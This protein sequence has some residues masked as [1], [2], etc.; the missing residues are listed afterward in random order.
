MLKIE[1]VYKKL[2]SNCP[3]NASQDS[4]KSCKNSKSTREFKSLLSFELICEIRLLR[5]LQREG[6]SNPA[7][8][9]FCCCKRRVVFCL[10]SFLKSVHRK[11][12]FL[13]AGELSVPVFKAV[14]QLPQFPLPSKIST[15]A[16]GYH[17]TLVSS[18]L[19]IV[20]RPGI[21][22]W[23][24]LDLFLDYFLEEYHGSS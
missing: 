24:F 12:M 2:P 17:R 6:K 19:L 20:L 3:Q 1:A 21:I 22:R 16:G 15:A 11:K 10:Y 9:V 4:K 18:H 23:N 7:L 14:E 13:T 8:S 5:A